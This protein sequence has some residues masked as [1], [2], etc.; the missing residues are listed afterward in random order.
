MVGVTGHRRAA[1]VAG[2]EDEPDQ[3]RMS[4]RAWSPEPAAVAAVFIGVGVLTGFAL[5]GVLSSDTTDRLVALDVVVAAVSWIASP[6]LLWRPVT[7]T[8]VFTV[9][10]ALSPTATPAASLGTLQVA[11]R[12]PFVQALGMALAGVAAHVVQG[13]WRLSAGISFN[14]WLVVIVACYGAILGWG[15]LAQ[16]HRALVTSL[17]DRARR[18]ER[19]QEHRVAE[20]RALERTRIAR[21]MHDVLAHR[22]SLL[23]TYAGA[24]EYRPDSA[25][26]RVAEAAGVVR[27]QAHQ[28]LDDLRDVLTV[29]RDDDADGSAPQPDIGDI[30]RLVEESQ[31]AGMSVELHNRLESASHPP[32]LV[33]RTAFR[34]VQEGLTNVRK[35]AASQR[36]NVVIEGSPGNGIEI[37]VRNTLP[38]DGAVKPSTGEGTGLIG[39]TERVALAGGRLTH[40]SLVG[41]FRLHARLPWPE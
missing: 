13:M 4:G 23:A 30:Q 6:I 21:E 9:L 25:P 27:A 14:W 5:W 3:R 29:L 31:Q 19:E 40:R 34:I 35:H 26:D 39:L 15:T 24:L 28:A 38:A 36:V 8:L 12:R 41:E 18:A 22:L 16:S 33:S 11:W 10:A 37:D 32:S 20:A 1:N 2:V 17:R 7:G